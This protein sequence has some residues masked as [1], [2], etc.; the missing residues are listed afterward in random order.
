MVGL[1][2]PADRAMTQWFKQA[3]DQIILLGTTKEDLG[4]TEYLRVV[5]HRE[6][7]SP[8]FLSLETEK[9]VQHCVLKLIREGLVQSAHDCSDG[10]LAVALAECCLTNS[11]QPLGAM[12]RLKAGT[13]R[14]DAL[15]F[16]E[17]QSRVVLSASPAHC[18]AVLRV[19]GEMGVEAAV[20][21]TVGGGR[22]LI[23][24][25]AGKRTSGCRIDADLQTLNEKWS[26]SLERSLESRET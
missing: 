26:R 7:G 10:G 12:V 22:L 18:E 4:G 20:I 9:G 14:L 19:A 1:I 13:L 3:G 16:G 2:E 11:T 17:S 25:E 15:L 8:P 21:G 5:H 24:V 6:Q 23:D